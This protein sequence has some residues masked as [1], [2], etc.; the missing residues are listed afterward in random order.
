MKACADRIEEHHR[1]CRGLLIITLLLLI[2]PI[3]GNEAQGHELNV[4]FMSTVGKDCRLTVSVSE[5]SGRKQT[6]ITRFQAD[7]LDSE[8]HYIHGVEEG[9]IEGLSIAGTYVMEEDV[10]EQDGT[11]RQAKSGDPKEKI[12]RITKTFSISPRGHCTF[13][14]GVVHAQGSNNV[15]RHYMW[16]YPLGTV[17]EMQSTQPKPRSGDL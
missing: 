13:F 3:H 11:Y 2:G 5:K 14:H 6:A 4:E 1:A 16:G 10:V 15:E 9:G 8:G 12:R 7:R 17:K